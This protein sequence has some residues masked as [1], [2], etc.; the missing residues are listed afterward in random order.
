MP[1]ERDRDL[2]IRL[3]VYDQ[4]K[5]EICRELGL[6]SLHFNRVL[7]RAKGRFKKILER[8]GEIVNLMPENDD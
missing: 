5:E 4:D 8:T 7:F 6:D 3:Y 2:L 1:V